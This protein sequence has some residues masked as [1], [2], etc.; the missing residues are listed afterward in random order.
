MVPSGTVTALVNTSGLPVGT[1]SVQAILAMPGLFGS[2][3]TASGFTIS[4]ALA[5][6]G[7]SNPAPI[8]LLGL[9]LIGIGIVTLLNSARKRAR[10][11]A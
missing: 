2:S 6:T 10:H 5:A 7:V 3:A 9:A 4:K 8:L 1:Y 11:K